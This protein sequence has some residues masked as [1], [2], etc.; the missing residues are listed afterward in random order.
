MPMIEATKL[1]APKAVAA[2]VAITST[3]SNRLRAW[4]GVGLGLGIGVGIRGSIGIVG[5]RAA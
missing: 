5:K 1:P 2:M 4:L 3:L